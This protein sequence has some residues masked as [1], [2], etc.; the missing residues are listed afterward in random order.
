[1]WL[2]FLCHYTYLVNRILNLSIKQKIA[3]RSTIGTLLKA[4]K[5]DYKTAS[6][7][8]TSFPFFRL[9][10]Q[11]VMKKTMCEN[12]KKTNKITHQKCYLENCDTEDQ[13]S[14]VKI[15]KNQH[16]HK[17]K[18]SISKKNIVD[19]NANKSSAKLISSIKQKSAFVWG[20][21]KFF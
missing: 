3:N 11:K 1:M 12:G 7:N 14:N 6:T 8:D 2:L 15:N 21:T 13:K 19:S 17:G 9:P 18:Q 10:C 20:K 4:S 5:A 16:K